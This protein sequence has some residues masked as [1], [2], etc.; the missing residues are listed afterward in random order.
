[1]D[2]LLRLL[3]SKKPKE[4]KDLKETREPQEPQAL[5]EANDPKEATRTRIEQGEA[6]GTVVEEGQNGV[7]SRDVS[8]TK[9]L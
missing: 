6:S 2:L 1:M 5:K 9:E 4:P 3:R 8:S 7:E